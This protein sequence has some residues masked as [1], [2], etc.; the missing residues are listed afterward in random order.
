MANVVKPR[1]MPS[2]MLG[3]LIMKE[4]CSGRPLAEQEARLDLAE[5]SWT[6]WSGWIRMWRYIGQHEAKRPGETEQPH[7][8]VRDYRDSYIKSFFRR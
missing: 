7:N 5:A 2:D 6:F 3:K 4:R 1:K 8:M